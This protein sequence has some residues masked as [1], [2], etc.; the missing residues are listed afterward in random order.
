MSLGQTFGR[1]KASALVNTIYY[2]P[3]LGH[4]VIRHPGVY[5]KSAAVIARNKTFAAKK[6]ASDR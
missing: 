2:K 6:P 3:S 4:W 1:K 5:R